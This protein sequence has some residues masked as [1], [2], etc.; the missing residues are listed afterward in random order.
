M[1]VVFVLTAS[2][3][4]V[5]VTDTVCSTVTQ[6]F[7]DVNITVQLLLLLLLLFWLH[8]ARFVFFCIASAFFIVVIPSMT[9][10]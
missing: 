7:L 9:K 1:L 10:A 5:F 2:I 8:V 4:D 3:L 6:V